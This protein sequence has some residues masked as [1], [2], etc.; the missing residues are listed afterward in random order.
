MEDD[1]SFIILDEEKWDELMAM[2]DAP[3][4]RLPGLL[5]LMRSKM[6]WSD[7]GK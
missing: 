7:D 6:P 5:K 4:K 1:E 2:L 3:P